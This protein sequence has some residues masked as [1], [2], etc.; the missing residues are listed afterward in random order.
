[1]LAGAAAAVVTIVLSR[2]GLDRAA[3]WLTVA[4]FVVSTGLGTGGLVL[5]WSS[6]KQAKTPPAPPVSGQGVD[7]GI[8]GGVAS[9]IVTNLPRDNTAFCGRDDELNEISRLI[10]VNRGLG[11]AVVVGIT[12]IG[13]LG[14]TTLAIRAAHEFGRQFPDAQYYLNLHAH[15]ATE[16][17]MTTGEALAALLRYAGFAPSALPS[18]DAD[19]SALWRDHAAG[20]R[21]LLVLD[22]V[23]GPEQVTD[24]VPGAAECLVLAT[25]R[26]RM[27]SL[28]GYVV[29][30]T[31]PTQ[32]RAVAMFR[33]ATVGS[34]HRGDGDVAALVRRCGYLPLTIRVAAGVLNAHPNWSVGDLIG[35]LSRSVQPE[36]EAV[37]DL[38]YRGMP[39]DLRRFF[40]H[41]GLHPGPVI[42]AT[43]AGALAGTTTEEAEA[44]LRTLFRSHL[45]DEPHPGRYVPHDCLRDYARRQAGALRLDAEPAVGRVI[46][47]YRRRA[48]DDAIRGGVHLTRHTRVRPG[49]TASAPRPRVEPA[50]RSAVLASFRTE[51]GNLLACL[52]HTRDHH[53]DA[54]TVGLADALAG[55]LRNDGPWDLAVAL[56]RESAAAAARLG[57]RS[58]QATALN[59]L[60]IMRR[61][62]GDL[63]GANEALDRARAI[64]A[65][66]GSHLGQANALNEKGIV[67]N[68][69]RDPGAIGLL[70]RALELYRGVG[71]QIGVANA[72]KNLWI[73]RQQAG[74]HDRATGL[75]E[76]ALDAYARI[77]DELGEAETRNHLGAMLLDRGGTDPRAPLAQFQRSQTLARRTGSL[78]EL[79]RALEGAGRCHHLLGEHDSAR[80]HLGHAREL[81]LRIGSPGGVDRVDTAMPTP[82]TINRSGAHR[83]G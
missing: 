58:A 11:R 81:Y 83:A 45:V 48:A 31:H 55:F 71:D 40:G 27:V 13:G 65:D 16:T 80:T 17:R 25:C 32:E 41:L 6:W 38:S 70:E 82:A 37:F 68:L 78:L 77:G 59:D 9:G 64:F 69:T 3:Q 5:A 67:A 61:L 57:D 63:V 29:V 22:D 73:A 43:A 49:G 52:R 20:R 36:V 14:K 21:I 10:A 26:D 18:S 47:H 79:A 60:G 30:L 2:Q 4:G 7:D 56:Y 35:D 66:L 15:S 24:L 8:A 28:D 72:A 74:E 12:G 54:R 19:R 1:M 42:D 34:I 76:T 44:W 50:E 33:A 53:D 62:T 23:S 46:D 51:R 75:L 39:A